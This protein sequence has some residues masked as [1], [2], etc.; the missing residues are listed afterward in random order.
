MVGALTCDVGEFE[1]RTNGLPKRREY[2]STGPAMNSYT[3]AAIFSGKESVR[4]RRLTWQLR[5]D[6][7]VPHG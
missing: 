3:A 6:R 2:C 7:G 4:A 1:W 5:A